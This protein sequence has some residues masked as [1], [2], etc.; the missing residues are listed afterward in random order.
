VLFSLRRLERD[1]L[2]DE[3]RATL[4]EAREGVA[5]AIE[6]VRDLIA[7]LRPKVLDD[8]GLGAAL[9]R[10]CATVARRSGLGVTPELSD[11]LDRL[12]ADVA[13]AAYRITQEALGNVVRHAAASRAGVS[14]AVVDDH[15][16]LTIDDDGK[17]FGPG[18]LGYG[19]KGM[20]ERARMV[21][22]RVDLERPAGGG[23]RIRFE[24]RLGL[25]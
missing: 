1:T 13:T 11:E 21:G 15:L 23:A 2:N 25:A 12:P 3:Q 24:T 4:A 5:A 20:I 14:A 18:T 7:D 6:D 8:F 10:L 17:G 16:I 19:I 22:G 9:E